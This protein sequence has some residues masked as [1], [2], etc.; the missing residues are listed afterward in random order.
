MKT[1]NKI[2]PSENWSE[3]G[4]WV[5][6]YCNF[7]VMYWNSFNGSRPGCEIGVSAADAKAALKLARMAIKMSNHDQAMAGPV[8]E[9]AHGFYNL[10][11]HSGNWLARRYVDLLDC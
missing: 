8:G 4:G 11:E 7:P 3:H 9:L 1:D 5:V 6:K 2:A 10:S